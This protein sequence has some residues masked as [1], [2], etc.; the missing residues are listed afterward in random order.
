MTV[1]RVYLL[2]HDAL[3]AEEFV[4][5]SQRV[6]EAFAGAVQEIHHIGSTAIPGIHAKPIIDMLAV[7]DDL[8]ALDACTTAMQ[9]LGYQVMGEFGMPGR[10]YFRKDNAAGHRTHQIHAFLHKSPQIT[11]HLAFRDFMRA[12]PYHAREYE[13][14]KLRLA[15]AHPQD[16]GAYT[17]GK[18]AFIQAMDAKAAVWQAAAKT[19]QQS[20]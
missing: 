15:T 7:V 9:A 3:W 18:D 13:Q 16:I 1:Q 6:Q 14:L 4:Q 11:R 19:T 10:R 17:D 2:P 5:E 8:S 12:H 20:A